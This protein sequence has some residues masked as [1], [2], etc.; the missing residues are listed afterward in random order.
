MRLPDFITS[1]CPQL[2]DEWEIFARTRL[3]AAGTMD[4]AQLRDHAAGMLQTIARNLCTPQTEHEQRQKSVGLGAIATVGG[5]TAAQSHGHD[6]AASGFTFVQMVSEFRALRASV[7]RLWAK[8]K[9]VLDDEDH[10][11]LMRFHEAI[12][13]A[14]A[15]ST[16]RYVQASEQA[17]QALLERQRLESAR[18]ELLRQLVNAEEKERRRIARDL[19]D[20]LGQQV[21]ALSLRLGVFKNMHG[22]ESP[23]RKELEGLLRIVRQIDEDLDFVVWELRPPVLDDL[24]LP[25]ALNEYAQSWSRHYNLPVRVRVAGLEQRLPAE[26]ESE[27][28]RILQEALNNIAKHARAQS[29]EVS[30]ETQAEQ[31]VLTVQDDGVGFEMPQGTGA[32][33][34]GLGL[35][36]MQERA[37]RLGAELAIDSEQGNGTRVRVS[38][39]V[40]RSL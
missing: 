2:V 33:G 19:H 27:L 23:V 30:F 29:V 34:R 6:R 21:T 28:Y 11:D 12:D 35:L 1:H 39:P 40:G 20:H 13:Q 32:D 9:P 3:P 36:G 17:A 5:S 38:V 14:L 22:I 31:V 18:V 10:R 4:R 8:A 25:D 24:G 37:T 26:V 16:D 7:L 15:E